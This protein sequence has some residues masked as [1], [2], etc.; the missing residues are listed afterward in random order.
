[1][2]AQKFKVSQGKYLAVSTHMLFKKFHTSKTQWHRVSSRIPQQKPERLER[3]GSTKATETDKTNSRF[4]RSV[5]STTDAHGSSRDGLQR[6]EQPRPPT[7]PSP[8]HM[9]YLWGCL[10]CSLQLYQQMF[11]VTSISVGMWAVWH[12][13]DNPPC[14]SS[15][16]LNSITY[17]LLGGCPQK[18]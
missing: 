18:T 15:F 13:S 2:I 8:A 9:G 10:C 5:C 6:S 1:M 7:L 14:L 17:H 16:P 11:P 4:C 12:C 3:Q